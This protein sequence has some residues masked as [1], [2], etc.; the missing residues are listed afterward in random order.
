[1]LVGFVIALV[2]LRHIKVGNACWRQP[3][4]NTFLYKTNRLGCWLIIQ[5]SV[6][7]LD[8]CQHC[9]AP[10]FQPSFSSSATSIDIIIL[11]L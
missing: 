4:E 9:R 6:S 1:M 5:D 11:N 8:K 10:S 7:Q 3:E 2:L